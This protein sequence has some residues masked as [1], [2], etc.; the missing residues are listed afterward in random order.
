M[1]KQRAQKRKR[2]S[3]EPEIRREEL[4]QVASALFREKG[5]AATGIGDITDRA[6]VARGTFYLYFTSKDALVCE[7]WKRYVQGF[8]AL[9]DQI[10]GAGDHSPDGHEIILELMAR[11]TRHAVDHAHLHRLVYG[12][13]DAAAI[14]LCRQSDEAILGRLTD[15]I[16][17][18]FH[19]V[20]R[21]GENIDLLASL[22]FQGLDGTLH[23]MIMRETPLDTETF[24]SE[25][26][27]FTVNVLQL[28]SDPGSACP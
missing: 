15:V 16:R 23:R 11:L 26:K 10:H 12:S 14:A 9:A 18:H 17:A 7:L 27:R 3:K 21:R 24:V 4:L 1:P 20:N 28:S 19:S 6:E 2:I 25:I 13:A 22:V 5:V 8:M